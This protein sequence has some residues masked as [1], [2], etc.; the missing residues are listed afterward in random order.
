MKAIV[1]WGL[2]ALACGALGGYLAAW[3]NR[4]WNFWTA[5]CF[6]VPPAILLLLILP[7]RIG[8][9]PSRPT[10]DQIDRS[11]DRLSL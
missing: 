8:P 4:D 6:L 10:L 1:V 9:T 7:K 2:T 5:W 3:K 11:E